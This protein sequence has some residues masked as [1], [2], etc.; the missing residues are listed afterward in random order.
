MA[1]T[2]QQPSSTPQT[3]SISVAIGSW[4]DKEYTPLIFPKGVQ[5]DERLKVY[6]TKFDHVEVNSSYHA[7]PR[8]AW[9]ESWVNQTPPGF[10]FDFKL[11][12]N[13]SQ[14]PAKAAADPDNLSQLREITRPLVEA[15]KLGAY[16][17]IL[18]PS[19]GPERRRLEELDRLVDE[20]KPHTLAV[21]LRHSGWIEDTQ[22]ERT[23][24]YF[25]AHQ[26][27]WIAVDMPR[28]PGSTIMPPVDEVT[29]P[30]LAYLR[31]H[32]RNENWLNAKSAEEKHTYLYPPEEL[33]SIA[34]R[35]RAL[36]KHAAVVHVVAN[37]HAE[38]FAPKT[39]LALQ[40]LLGL[41]KSGSVLVQD[42]M[43]L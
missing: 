7:Y 27:T 20:L 36:A 38:D 21:E 28:I 2:E 24:D 4:T 33:E 11:H 23:L 26:I 34:T 32:G 3:P 1:T 30:R 12:R 39:A 29:N 31:L 25:R 42:E 10:L 22:R 16:F 43:K 41:R 40:D 5:S 35:V 8:R 15:G 6:A 14:S 9:V 17:L 37:N 13:F 19:F 18:P